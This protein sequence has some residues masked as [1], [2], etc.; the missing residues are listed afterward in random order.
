MM[1]AIADL[2]GPRHHPGLMCPALAVTVE[3]IIRHL[4]IVTQT[5]VDLQ[6]LEVLHHTLREGA[7]G[8]LVAIRQA[9][10]HRAAGLL[11]LT[12]RAG[13]VAPVGVLLPT[14]QAEVVLLPGRARVAGLLAGVLGVVPP[15]LEVEAGYKSRFY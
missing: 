10:A 14:H 13:A 8:V 11:P 1:V 12:H 15:G 9:E 3:D 4:L 2:Q 5:T 7:V 6:A